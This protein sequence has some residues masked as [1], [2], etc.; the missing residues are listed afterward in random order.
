[1]IKIIGYLILFIS[2]ACCAG[3]PEEALKTGAEQPEIYLPELQHKNVGLVVNHTSQVNGINLVD[4]LLSKNIHVK[5]IFA[6]EHGFRGNVSAG[7][8]IKDGADS[9]TGIPVVSLYGKNRKPTPGQLHG[10]DLVIFDVQDVGC[11]FYTYI[12]TLHLVLEACAQNQV[13]LLVLDRPNPNGDYVA[14]PVLQPKFRSFVGMD[15]IPI[16]HGCTVGELA[17]MINGEHWIEGYDK[18]DLTV[19]PV[20]NYTHK[21][22]YSL[23]VKPS[24]NLPNDLSV[25]L[26]PS[27][28]FFEATSISVGRG[29]PF[30]FQVL[31]GTDSTLGSFAFVPKN[32]P[33][34]A[35]N[36]LNEGKVCY[37]IDLRSLKYVP[38]FTL[39]YFLEFYHHYNN[40][41]DFLIRENWL[42]LLAGNDDLIRQ[43]RG[44]KNEA[45]ITRS[46][47]PELSK[48]KE[49][50]KKYLLYPDFE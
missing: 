50:R 18:C 25:R 15:P 13:P 27:L 26:Y 30:P 21:M 24:P 49:I 36:P 7:E 46:W 17:R 33:G 9:K 10:L 12:S 29:T 5:T 23:P 47:Q 3:L 45:E 32:I 8:E 19:I 28:C 38:E 6:P 34:V 11:R 4:F 1:M 2:L 16:V 35:A 39:K 20:K 31:G 43:I 42:N 22:R 37:G 41:K 40:E 48:Y 44:G 14:G